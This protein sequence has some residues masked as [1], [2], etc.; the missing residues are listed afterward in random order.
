MFFYPD[1]LKYSI[2]IWFSATPLSFKRFCER[3]I[4][5]SGKDQLLGESVPKK[6]FYSLNIGGKRILMSSSNFVTCRHTETISLD[7]SIRIPCNWVKD[8]FCGAD[9]R[10]CAIMLARQG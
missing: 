4:L 10:K 3:K 8:G 5:S 6:I 2:N 7:T 9:G 1:P